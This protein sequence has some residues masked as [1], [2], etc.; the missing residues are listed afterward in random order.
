MPPNQRQII[1]QVK[2]TYSSLG[3]G[4][5]KQ[6]KEKRLRSK[7]KKK[8]NIEHQGEKSQTQIKNQFVLSIQ[9]IF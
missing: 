8:K 3:K 4:F 6:K 9:K 5:K 2:F 7:E 1:E